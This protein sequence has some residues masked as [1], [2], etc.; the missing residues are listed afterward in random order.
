[1]A[2]NQWNFP[3]AASAPAAMSQGTAG[4]GTPIWSKKTAPNIM[5]KP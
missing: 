3:A 5:G 1:M 4:I 2:M